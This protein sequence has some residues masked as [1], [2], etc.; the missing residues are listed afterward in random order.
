VIASIESQLGGQ[1]EFDWRPEGLICRLSVPLQP[2]DTARQRVKHQNP[3]INGNGSE[4]AARS[5]DG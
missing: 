4:L 1:A 5:A 3:A 2:D